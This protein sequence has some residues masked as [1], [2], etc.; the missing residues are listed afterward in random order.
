LLWLLRD[1]RLRI[2]HWD[3]L[4]RGTTVELFHGPPAAV[5]KK[6]DHT[7]RIFK[8]EERQWPAS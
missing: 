1:F 8:L 5:E 3:N 4:P 2:P 7:E 6:Q